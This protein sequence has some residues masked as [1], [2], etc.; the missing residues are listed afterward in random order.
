MK[1]TV[2]NTSTDLATLLKTGHG[3]DILSKIERVRIKEPG[4]GSNFGVLLKNGATNSVYFTNVLTAATATD[5]FPI[6]ASEAVSF[7]VRD[8]QNVKLIAGV[9]AQEVWVEIF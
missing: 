4:E 6:S 7:D 8:L 3:D 9:A 2:T 5:G 1:I